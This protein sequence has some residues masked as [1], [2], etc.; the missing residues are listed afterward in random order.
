M[1]AVLY[2]RKDPN[3]EKNTEKVGKIVSRFSLIS[4]GFSIWLVWG[5]L[6][7]PEAYG[8]SWARDGIHTT[9]LTMSDP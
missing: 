9:V 6:A 7:L 3:Q 8:S 4:L 5:F 1:Y 2:T